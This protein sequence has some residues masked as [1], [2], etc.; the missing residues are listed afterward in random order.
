MNTEP[1]QRGNPHLAARRAQKAALLPRAAQL[2]GEGRSYREIAAALG[3]AKSTVC[4]WLRG[5]PLGRAA[6][7]ALGTPRMT[8]K[9]AARYELLYQRALRE[10]NR[11]K[12]DR[13]TQ[14]V[15]TSEPAEGG[16]TTTTTV[17]TEPRT[18]NA[19]CLGKALAA[20]K[21]MEGLH[22]RERS[23]RE[24]AEN[25]KSDAAGNEDGLTRT[26]K[27]TT[28]P[29][30]RRVR[31]VV[32]TRSDAAC[33][34]AIRV[35]QEVLDENRRAL[36]TRLDAG[37][38]AAADEQTCA[39]DEETRAADEETRAAIRAEGDAAEEELQAIEAR[40]DAAK[41]AAD[42]EACATLKVEAAAVEEKLQAAEARL[43]AAR[44][45][46]PAGSPAI[47]ADQQGGEA[48]ERAPTEPIPR[49]ENGVADTGSARPEITEPAGRIANPSY[50]ISPE[51]EDHSY[52]GNTGAARPA[53]GGAAGMP[54]DRRKSWVPNDLHLRLDDFAGVSR[55]ATLPNDVFQ[56]G[57]AGKG[58]KKAKGGRRK[59]VSPPA[60]ESTPRRGSAATLRRELDRVF[61]GQG[62]SQSFPG[63]GG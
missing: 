16:P 44:P 32:T 15:V 1:S 30:G 21:A 3:I 27:T 41:E 4:Q 10:W 36:E 43:D 9:L 33:L 60:R 40:I 23:R 57:G 19:A 56:K 46:A 17:R 48:A 22:C 31:T 49:T 61:D 47:A 26:V 55:S 25:L 63:S 13:R 37:E 8:A 58:R 14:T 52:R 53:N 28:T 59:P 54:H 2:A 42:E 20:L 12:A 5:R 18:G 50:G 11:S 62:P 35:N 7:Q 38:D 6:A 45:A 34:A 29:S 39:A 24:W 51:G